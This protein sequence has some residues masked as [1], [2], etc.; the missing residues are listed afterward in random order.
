VDAVGDDRLADT[1]AAQ[2]DPPLKLVHA[3]LSAIF[4]IVLSNQYNR[5][6]RHDSVDCPDRIDKLR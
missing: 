5:P 3:P 2:H 4:R 6:R 1:R